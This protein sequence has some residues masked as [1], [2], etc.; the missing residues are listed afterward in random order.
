MTHRAIIS[1]ERDPKHRKSNGHSVEGDQGRKS[2]GDEHYLGGTNM[3]KGAE[4]GQCGLV[5]SV[6]TEGANRD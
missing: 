5:E 6:T 2:R 4:V 3:C 1:T